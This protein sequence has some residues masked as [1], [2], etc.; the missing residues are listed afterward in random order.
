MYDLRPSSRTAARRAGFGRKQTFEF[1]GTLDL[2]RVDVRHGDPV[3][4]SVAV[5]A[6][7]RAPVGEGG[8]RQES[9]PVQR[10]V[11]IDQAREL[12]AC[13]GKKPQ[14]EFGSLALGDVV[15][16]AYITLLPRRVVEHEFS[17]PRHPADLSRVR[18]D[19]P[20]LGIVQGVVGQLPVSGDDS[21]AFFLVNERDEI[22]DV[23]FAAHRHSPQAAELL[24]RRDL[25]GLRHQFERADAA[26]LLRNAQALFGPPFARAVAQYLG[27][28]DQE[29]VF[30]Q[31]R[32]LFRRPEPRSVTLD[33]PSFMH[34]HAVPRGEIHFRFPCVAGTVL[35]GEKN[36]GGFAYRLPGRPAQDLFGA[37]TPADDRPRR[38]Q[39]H[40]RVIAGVVQNDASEFVGVS[41]RQFLY[42]IFLLRHAHGNLSAF[43]ALRRP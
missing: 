32:Q 29:S 22:R 39:N 42:R 2:G 40:D 26:G 16:N 37:G 7:D 23:I 38:I 4:G 12:G 1:L 3:Q 21:S 34:R 41:C 18:P 11:L 43:G 24:G 20:V 27:I 31:C 33:E 5:Q 36:F 19:D 35:R 13:A 15:R 8:H 10:A 30:D 14:V 9:E 6:I 28:A 25:S 17:A